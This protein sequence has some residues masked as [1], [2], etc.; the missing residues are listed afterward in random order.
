MNQDTERIP[1]PTNG[2]GPKPPDVAPVVPPLDS[3][4]RRIGDSDGAVLR[5]Q[6]VPF[7]PN[8]LAVGFGIV[9]GLLLLFAGARRRRGGRGE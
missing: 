7:T 9:A 4:G 2:T 8:Q 3:A 6:T 1:V 5:D